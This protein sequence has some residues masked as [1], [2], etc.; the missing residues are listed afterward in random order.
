MSGTM[1]EQ[2]QTMI[3][4]GIT[5]Q[6]SNSTQVGSHNLNSAIPLKN[7]R[8]KG[9][10]QAK[11]GKVNDKMDNQTKIDIISKPKR[12]VLDIGGQN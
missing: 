3:S 6:N 4:P 11:K 10:A 1:E 5:F 2:L 8:K 12:I 7:A 9:L